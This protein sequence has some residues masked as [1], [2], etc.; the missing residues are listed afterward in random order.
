MPTTTTVYQSAGVGFA[1]AASFS[2]ITAVLAVAHCPNIPNDYTH[3][4]YFGWFLCIK[5]ADE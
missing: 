5:I 1:A 3:T 2:C 4:S